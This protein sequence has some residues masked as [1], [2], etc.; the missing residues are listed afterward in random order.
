MNH[1]KI[2]SFKECQE[3]GVEVFNF[4]NGRQKTKA[5]LCKQ[6]SEKI[7]EQRERWDEE[8][9]KIPKTKVVF[10]CIRCGYQQ[11]HPHPGKWV[12]K[13]GYGRLCLKCYNEVTP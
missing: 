10:T 13:E 8:G 6:H 4:F 2:C 9:R 1:N 12:T 11:R 3:F 7:K 5:T